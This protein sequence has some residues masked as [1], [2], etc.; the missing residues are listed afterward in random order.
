MHN[1][2]HI[3]GPCSF[4][5]R[6]DGQRPGLSG[7][8]GTGTQNEES[9]SMRAAMSQLLPRP[10]GYIQGVLARLGSL[11]LTPYGQRGHRRLGSALNLSLSCPALLAPAVLLLRVSFANI[12]CIPSLGL[13]EPVPSMAVPVLQGQKMRPALGCHIR[14]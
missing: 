13:L 7:G 1:L 6:G 3:K 4:F 12:D 9:I 5:V 10:R 14:S 8:M 2:S 11:S